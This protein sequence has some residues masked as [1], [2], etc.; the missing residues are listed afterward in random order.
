M[1]VGGSSS[2]LPSTR[3]NFLLEEA[4]LGQAL[5]WPGVGGDGELAYTEQGLAMSQA[6]A[7]PTVD[8]KS[9]SACP[10]GTGWLGQRFEVLWP[11]QSGKE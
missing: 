9:S 6:G 11:S 7:E 3:G 10:Q 8:W 5:P 1:C 4:L 2:P